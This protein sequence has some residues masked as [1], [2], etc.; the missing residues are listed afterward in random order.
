VQTTR[1]M[2][3]DGVVASL[4]QPIP[5][6]PRHKAKDRTVR[7]HQCLCVTEARCWTKQPTAAPEEVRVSSR[8]QKAA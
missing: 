5:T 4:P 1:T 2:E 7:C 6:L 8:D 3:G